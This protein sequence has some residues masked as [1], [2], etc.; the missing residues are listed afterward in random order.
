MNILTHFEIDYLSNFS[1]P[2]QNDN[3]KE[4]T[5]QNQYF[6]RTKENISEQNKR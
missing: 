5:L 6:Q 2:L 4:E 1:L 3:S